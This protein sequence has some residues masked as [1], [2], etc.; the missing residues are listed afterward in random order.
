MSASLSQ[1]RR[2]QFRAWLIQFTSQ[3]AARSAGVST[4]AVRRWK[5]KEGFPDSEALFNLCRNEGL[6]LTALAN[7]SFLIID[8]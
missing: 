2:A 8:E 5:R 4:E 7:G 3:Q 6:D 1:R